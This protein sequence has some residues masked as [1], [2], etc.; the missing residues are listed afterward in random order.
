MHTLPEHG[1]VP[2]LVLYIDVQTP[3]KLRSRIIYPSL[4]IL[5]NLSIAVEVGV[6]YATYGSAW[7]FSVV[8]YLILA[9]EDAVSNIAY[10]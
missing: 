5:G 2:V 4:V 1:E 7:L 6:T 9:L 3:C 8:I 10:L